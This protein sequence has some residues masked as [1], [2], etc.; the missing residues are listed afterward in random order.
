MILSQEKSIGVKIYILPGSGAFHRS[1]PFFS[2]PFYGPLLWKSWV[3]RAW[4]FPACWDCRRKFFCNLCDH[5][6]HL[7]EPVADRYGRKAMMLRASIAMTLTM[8]GI[9]FVPSVFLAL[10]YLHACSMGSFQALSPI[11]YSLDCQ[12]SSQDQ[13]GYALGTLSTSVVAGT[14]MGAFDW[15]THC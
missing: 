11:R 7:G 3:L 4:L 6:S 9:A 12:P 5:V 13:S 15:R 14:L 8:G 2:R 1:Q 10:V